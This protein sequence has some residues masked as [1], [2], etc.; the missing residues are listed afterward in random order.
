[1]KVE[2][3]KEER[4]EKRF[5]QALIFTSSRNLFYVLDRS[6]SLVHKLYIN[7]VKIDNN[8]IHNG[9]ILSPRPEKIKFG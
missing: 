8:R 6:N 2:E 7:V 9:T 3:E 5:W 4:E 1:M